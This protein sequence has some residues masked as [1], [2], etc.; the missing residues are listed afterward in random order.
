[1][2][3][4]TQPAHR[5]HNNNAQQTQHNSPQHSKHSKHKM[6]KQPCSRIECQ[7][8]AGGRG[9]NPTA[10]Q[11][12]HRAQ[13]DR[14][15][16][17]QDKP[18]SDLARLELFHGSPALQNTSAAAIYADMEAKQ[19][20]GTDIPKENEPVLVSPDSTNTQP[21]FEYNQGRIIR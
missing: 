17:L 1:M 18:P 5:R 19:M 13:P 16:C 20:H 6:F 10:C 3:Q 12:H 9:G 2:A 8:T 15:E 14:T 7:A 11:E 4:E 21:S